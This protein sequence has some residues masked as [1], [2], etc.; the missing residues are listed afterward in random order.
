MSYLVNHVYCMSCDFQTWTFDIS[1]DIILNI[2][3]E[4]DM[5]YAKRQ[6][7][8]STLG[9]KLMRD[10]ESENY[11][12]AKWEKE[13]Y[14]ASCK[15]DTKIESDGKLCVEG[16][17]EIKIE[18][19]EEN[20]IPNFDKTQDKIY[21]SN[22]IIPSEKKKSGIDLVS[23]L[24]GY[25][26]T[27]LLNNKDNFYTCEKCRKTVDIDKN[28]MFITS[29]YRLYDMPPNIA[30]SLKRFRQSTTSFGMFGGGG[31]FSKINTDVSFPFKLDFSPYVMSKYSF[32]LQ[33]ITLT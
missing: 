9:R 13:K 6:M 10:E 27:N 5:F 33:K 19:F 14:D 31:S 32:F 16:N 2:D 25:F 7:R 21:T 8:Y 17:Y 30:I 4:E 29:T 26:K 28:I 23:L 20:M 22:H 11:N 15:L 3:E 1:S 12:S 18:A 24:D